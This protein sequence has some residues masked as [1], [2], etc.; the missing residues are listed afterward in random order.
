MHSLRFELVH[1]NLAAGFKPKQKHKRT[2]QKNQETEIQPGLFQVTANDYKSMVL[3]RPHAILQEQGQQGRKGVYRTSSRNTFASSFSS[4]IPS[5][6]A[7]LAFIIDCTWAKGKGKGSFG[8]LFP[9][10]WCPELT[11][12]FLCKF[13]TQYSTNPAAN[14]KGG[15]SPDWLEGSEGKDSLSFSVCF[16]P[17]TNSF[18]QGAPHTSHSLLNYH[19][20][21]LTL[22]FLCFNT[23]Q[24]QQRQLSWT[25]VCGQEKRSYP[26]WDRGSW[27]RVTGIQRGLI[28]VPKL[29]SSL[30]Q[31]SSR[32]H[33]PHSPPYLAF[34][35]THPPIP[36]LP[37]LLEHVWS[38]APWTLCSCLVLLSSSQ[39]SRHTVREIV[40]GWRCFWC[41]QQSWLSAVALTDS[42]CWAPGRHHTCSNMN[43]KGSS[44]FWYTS[45]SV[46]SWD[47]QTEGKKYW[48][49]GRWVAALSAPTLAAF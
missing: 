14:H 5:I 36:L 1:P 18:P 32:A 16:F 29:P 7:C 11:L 26:V 33:P 27:R 48:S 24:A 41:A 37:L 39:V 46:I 28:S 23:L 19:L 2:E 6:S 22:N 25:G 3:W 4:N 42:P 13:C 35:R 12:P 45:F 34:P 8:S 9:Y 17:L 44:G 40:I 49:L 10:H 38:L 31:Q 21:P 20:T 30:R 47:R 15:A 43:C